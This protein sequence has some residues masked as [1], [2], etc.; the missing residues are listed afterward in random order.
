MKNK[1]FTL[2]ELMI[3]IAIIG[4]I[5]A[6]ALPHLTGQST[7]ESD[8]LG[9]VYRNQPVQ[10]QAQPASQISCQDGVKVIINAGSMQ[11]MKDPQGNGIPCS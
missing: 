6:V 1:G 5:A 9:L 10:Q 3:V 4:I 8:P 11:Q 7:S 2:I